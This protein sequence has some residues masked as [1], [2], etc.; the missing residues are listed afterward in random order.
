M[1]I[2]RRMSTKQEWLLGGCNTNKWFHS[3]PRF[4]E[5]RTQFPLWTEQLRVRWKPY[6]ERRRDPLAA[7]KVWLWL[8]STQLLSWIALFYLLSWTGCWNIRCSEEETTR[9]YLFHAIYNLRVRTVAEIKYLK[10]PKWAIFHV[11]EKMRQGESIVDHK[12]C[13]VFKN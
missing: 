8:N 12:I 11:A 2:K 4:P 5:G 10:K 13:K 1:E 9:E 6:L 7:K 3:G